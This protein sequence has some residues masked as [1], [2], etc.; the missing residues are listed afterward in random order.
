MVDLSILDVQQIFGRAGRPQFD[1]SGEATLITNHEALPRYIDKLVRAV[2]I[3]SNFI[4]QLADHL[5]AEVVGGT[6]SSLNDAVTWI[7]YTYLFVR[8][9]KNPLAYGINADQF[10]DDPMLRG[11][12]RELVQQAATL[13]AQNKMMN[14][15]PE[16]GNL[17]MTDLGRVAAHFYV[18]A[19]SVKTFNDMME[20]NPSPSDSDLCRV[21]ASATEFT[22]LRVRQE[23]Q[24]ELDGLQESCPLKYEGQ[25]HDSTTK[26]FVL[27]QAFISRM[28]IKSFTLISDTNYIA[29][30]AGEFCHK[31]VLFLT[32]KS[33]HSLLLCRSGVP[34]YIRNV[35]EN[36]PGIHSA[37]DATVCKEL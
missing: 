24:G 31:N 6:V 32:T 34:C 19:E 26:S 21:I 3:E 27:M 30:N 33:S 1:T 14:F 28:K 15:H 17:S 9:K 13:L 12:C 16:S 10:A 36:K 23:E 11:R 7:G 18:Q 5:N 8:M 25:V 22:N 29:A 20:L 2:P 37:Q 35:H 4:K